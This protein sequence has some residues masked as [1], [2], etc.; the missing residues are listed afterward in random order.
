MENE[1]NNLEKQPE[2]SENNLTYHK[3]EYATRGQ[4]GFI[5]GNPGRPNGIPNKLTLLKNKLAEYAEANIDLDEVATMYDKDGNPYTART[6]AKL[7]I[8]KLA[9]SLIPKEQKLE[10]E[11]KEP[12]T[13]EIKRYDKPTDAE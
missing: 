6:L 9:V 7:D 2:S 1:Q 5:E 13:I 11:H 12:I 4:R 3:S 10:V 8:L